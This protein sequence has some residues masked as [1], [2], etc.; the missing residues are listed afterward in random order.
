[1][2]VSGVTINEDDLT[3]VVKSVVVVVSISSSGVVIGLKN[4]FIKLK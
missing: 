1:M 3:N 2:D 4:F